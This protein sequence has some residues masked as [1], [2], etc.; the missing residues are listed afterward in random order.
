MI[1]RTNQQ[2][3]QQRWHWDG[4]M[5]ST[6]KYGNIYPWHYN[7]CHYS[8]SQLP[9]QCLFSSLHIS[10]FIISQSSQQ[11]SNARWATWRSLSRILLAPTAMVTL[12][13]MEGEIDQISEQTN[14]ANKNTK[15]AQNSMKLLYRYDFF[16]RTPTAIAPGCDVAKIYEK[17]VLSS[18]S[19]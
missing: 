1:F 18:I 19:K 6:N 5:D 9:N 8:L 3:H 4:W 12:L 13:Q 17:V 2:L 16:C 7:S 11:W 14:I 15:E 10:Y